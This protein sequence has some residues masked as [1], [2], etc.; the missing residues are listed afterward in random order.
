MIIWT[1]WGFLG[2]VIPFTISLI[3]ELI[4][5]SMMGQDAY[6]ETKLPLF[7][8]LILSAGILHFLAKKFTKPSQTVIDKETKKELVLTRKNTLL[9][10]ELQY[11]PIIWL[12]IAF[13]VLLFR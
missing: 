4:T 8:A 9:F 7:L 10:V 1:N 13:G 12:V 11:W 3:A 5:Q 2:F 6:Q